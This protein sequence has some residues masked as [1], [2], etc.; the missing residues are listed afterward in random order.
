MCRFNLEKKKKP[1]LNYIFRYKKI[2]FSMGN[3]LFLESIKSAV[4]CTEKYDSVL[5]NIL[6]LTSM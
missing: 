4:L 2:L 6:R 3:K 5:R 1:T